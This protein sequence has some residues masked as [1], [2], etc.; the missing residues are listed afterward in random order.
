MR[1]ASSGLISYGGHEDFFRLFEEAKNS[2]VPLRC[3]T[4]GKQLLLVTKIPADSQSPLALLVF[5]IDLERF[6]AAAIDSGMESAAHNTYV[7]DAGRQYALL[8]DQPGVGRA[9]RDRRQTAGRT[10]RSCSSTTLSSCAA[11]SIRTRRLAGP[12]WM[13]QGR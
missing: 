12:I 13:W 10:S 1:I 3:Q 8:A 4:A 11:P 7:M 5:Q 6:L 2:A 9:A